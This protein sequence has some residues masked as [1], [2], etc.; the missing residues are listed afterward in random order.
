MLPVVSSFSSGVL[1]IAYRRAS[2]VTPFSV[3][4]PRVGHGDPGSQKPDQSDADHQPGQEDHRPGGPQ[5]PV[6]LRTYAAHTHTR[7]HTRAMTVMKF[8][9]WDRLLLVA[10]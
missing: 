2:C 5:A 6:G 4:V 3:P 9:S 7:T 8:H 10:S 1:H